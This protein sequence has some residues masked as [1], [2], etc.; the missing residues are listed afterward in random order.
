MALFKIQRNVVA[1]QCKGAIVRI[2]MR[3]TALVIGSGWIRGWAGTRI[4]FFSPRKTDDGYRCTGF[5]FF[6]W[7]A[8]DIAVC[9]LP[10]WYLATTRAI[11]FRFE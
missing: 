2:Q 4:G 7:L 5:Y 10:R 9:Q 8:P 1:G 3:Y 6:P 11:S